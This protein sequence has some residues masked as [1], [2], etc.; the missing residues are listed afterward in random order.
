MDYIGLPVGLRDQIENIE[1]LVNKALAATISPNRDGS[2]NFDS[3][4]DALTLVYSIVEHKNILLFGLAELITKIEFNKEEIAD[5]MIY[6]LD[7]VGKLTYEYD[8]AHICQIA[9]K[10]SMERHRMEMAKYIA[11]LL[12]ESTDQ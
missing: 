11:S 6:V 7:L 4:V 5:A 8:Q 12:N 1:R 3:L 10:M 2:Y 9:D